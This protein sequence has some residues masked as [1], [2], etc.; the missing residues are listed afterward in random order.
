V[1]YHRQIAACPG[2]GEKLEASKG[3][4]S[5]DSQSDRQ[6]KQTN[7]LMSIVGLIGPIFFVASAID[8]FGK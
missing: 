2:F 5:A 7:A 1:Q 4:A 3:E 6:K 8:G